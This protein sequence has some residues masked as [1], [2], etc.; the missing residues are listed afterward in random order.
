MPE[1]QGRIKVRG[2][3][4]RRSMRT[5]NKWRPERVHVMSRNFGLKAHE[6]E[7]LVWGQS[8]ADSSQWIFITLGLLT[9]AV[10]AVALLA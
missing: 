9:V 3:V 10:L 4:C 1:S 2:N 8:D 5:M 7:D 6:V